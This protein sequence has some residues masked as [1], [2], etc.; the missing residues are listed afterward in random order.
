M[1]ERAIA[2]STMKDQTNATAVNK[3]SP[4]FVG[5]LPSAISHGDLGL[6]PGTKPQGKRTRRGRTSSYPGIFASTKCLGPA[7]FE[8]LLERDFQTL[9][10]CDPR[11]EAYA[12]QAHVLKYWTPRSDGTF[13]QRRYTPDIVARL[14]DGRVLVIEVKA[15]FFAEEKYWR[16]REPYIRDAYARDYALQFIVVTERQIRIQP[17]LSNFERLLR[18]GARS[19]D[20]VAEI[21]VRDVL[22]HM[23]NCPCIGD[24]CASVTLGGNRMSR[25]YAA[26]MRLALHGEITLD[27]DQPLSL[28]TTIIRKSQNV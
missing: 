16:E 12:V 9:L 7:L 5:G 24:V 20:Q 6:F 17:R 26:L 19:D 23:P 14:R 2:P 21:E 22:D 28:S 11:V 10:C 4:T 1:I 18:Y 15:A 8:S 3:S 27:L 13:T 25:T